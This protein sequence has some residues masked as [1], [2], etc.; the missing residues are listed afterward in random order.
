MNKYSVLLLRPDYMTDNYGQDT[1]Y[2]WVKADTPG[3]AIARARAQ[4]I[5]ADDV[6]DPD[7]CN[8]DD[9]AVLLVLAGYQ[10]GLAW[11]WEDR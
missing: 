3:H 5:K 1:Y 9:Y 8:P 11:D 7:N 2:A 6:D 4:V 10:Q